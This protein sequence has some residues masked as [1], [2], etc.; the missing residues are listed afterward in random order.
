MQVRI[1]KSLCIG[2]LSILF[3]AC[4]STRPNASQQAWTNEALTTALANPLRPKADR[5]RDLARKPAQLMT[6]FGV[7]RGMATADFLAAG[8][9]MTEVL[10]VSVG[11]TGKVYS[12]DFTPNQAMEERLNNDRLPNVVR[13]VGQATIAPNTLDFAILCMNLHDIYNSSNAQAM[14]NALQS[15]YGMFKP[16]GIF[17]IVDHVGVNGADN[18]RLHRMTKQQAIDVV[19]AAGFSLEAESDMLAQQSDDHSKMVTD[20]LVRGQTDQFILKFRKPK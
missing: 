13:V 2:L 4:T 5:D 3:A 1:S 9:F 16:G 7:E 20:P 10:S 15:V 14:Q 17:G 6:F 11:P 12:Q 8:G 18:A 19:T